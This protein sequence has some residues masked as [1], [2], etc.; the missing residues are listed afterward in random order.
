MSKDVPN[1]DL[2]QQSEHASHKQTDKPWKG[3]PEKEQR[4][5]DAEIDLESGIKLKRIDLGGAAAAAVEWDVMLAMHAAAG[6][7]AA[8]SART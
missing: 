3:I 1:D 4:N 5:D 6:R 7:A 8:G 2:N